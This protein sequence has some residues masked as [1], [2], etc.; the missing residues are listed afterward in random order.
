MPALQEL[1]GYQN[2]TR[3]IA[4]PKLG[5]P[6]LLPPG[7]FNVSDRVSG[8]YAQWD[9]LGASRQP[10]KYVPKG[11]PSVR[12][13]LKKIGTQTC[14]IPG[15]FEHFDYDAQVLESLRQESAPQLQQM[16]VQRLIHETQE[17]RRQL[18]NNRALMAQMAIILN[19]IHYGGDGEVLPSA[20]GAAFSIDYQVPA[21][22][23]TSGLEIDASTPLISATWATA[24]TKIV[25]DIGRI[26]RTAVQRA[27]M[28][29]QWAFYGQNIL[30][31][32]LANTQLKEIMNR[33]PVAQSSILG[34]EI[35][36]GF[37]GLNWVPVQA[38]FFEQADGTFGSPM[39]ADNI[40]FTPDPTPDWFGWI[41]GTFLVPSMSGEGGS[42]V[43]DILGSLNLTHGKF[44]YASVEIDPPALR[45]YYGDTAL[46]VIKVP[47][48]VYRLHTTP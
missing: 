35:P 8:N 37:M 47:S 40:I 20:S 21:S 33:N 3:A 7:F 23:H 43:T 10:M 16:G 31:H 41:E 32:F 48:A 36:D 45:Q 42:T 4:D 39:D 2:L 28:P 44:S 34:G 19:K 13:E 6:T 9:I 22:N 5:L 14:I 24:S 46:P 30:D 17:M 29:L 15:F 27:G 12:R 25:T 38:S 11:A 1:I 26:K 18:D